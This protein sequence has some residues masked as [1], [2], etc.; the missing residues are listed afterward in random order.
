LAISPTTASIRE[1]CEIC[2]SETRVF[3]VDVDHHSHH[4]RCGHAVGE[5]EEYIQAALAL[6]F[7]E[8]GITDHA[9]VYWQEGDHAL[10]GIAM[11]RSE[12]PAYVD[13][14][15]A[16]KKKY[17]GRIRVLLGLE[18]D[19]VPGFDDQ[20]REVL[21]TYPFDYVI[22]SVHHCA[23]HHIYHAR[24]WETEHPE[25]TYPEYFRL[26]RESAQSGLFDVL[27]HITGLMAYGPKPSSALLEAE[28]TATAAALAESGVAIEVNSSG[29]RKGGPEPFPA[30]ALLQRCLDAG[31][32][33]TYGS[34]S[35]RPD[36]VGYAREWVAMR[37]EGA[38]RWRPGLVACVRTPHRL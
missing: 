6:G 13:E 11:A 3:A 34:D 31:V 25:E 15:L 8:I 36:E 22:G 30:G 4:R 17:A 20:Y 16:L 23:G 28:F 24:R 9:P 21:T 5:I 38:R 35:H 14:V 37:L 10:P 32:P 7:E 19:Y 29:L 27:G 33:V 12:L 1:I 26:I 18:S 2:G